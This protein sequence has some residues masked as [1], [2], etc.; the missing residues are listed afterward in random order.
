M[1]RFSTR[2]LLRVGVLALV[3]GIATVSTRGQAPAAK[4]G[5]WPTYGGDLAS[6]RYSPLDQINASNFSKLQLAFR[7]KTENLGPRPE[8]QFQSTP[9]MVNGRLFTTA[10]TRRA[11]V[12]L[13]ATT[14]EMLWMH[15]VD[16]GKRGEAA[17]RQLS[18]RGLSY[19]T[20]GKE[21][22]IIYVTPGYQMVALDA[23]TGLR[24]PNFGAGGIVDLKTGLDQ[25]GLD[26]TTAEIGLHAAPIISKDIIV[27]GAAHREGGFPKSKT[28]VKGYIRGFDVRT[29]KRVWVFHTI[30]MKG[31]AGYE[32]WD[33]DAA[34]YTGNAGVWAQMS[35]DEELGIVYMPVELPTGDY[36]GGHRHGGKGTDSALYGESLV[37]LDIKTGQKKWHYQLV[38]HGIWDHDIPC[39]PILMDLVVDGKPVKAVA[40]PTKQNWLYVFDRATGKPVWPIEERPVEKGDVPGEWYSPTQPFVTKPPAYERQGV[41]VNDLIDYTPELRAE[42]EKLV[43]Q[44]KIGPIFTPPVVSKWEGPRG[45]LMLPDVTGGANWQG[46]SFDPE[47]KRFYIFTN[48]TI[49][50]LGLLPPNE[51]QSDMLFGRGAA[52]NPNPAPA[53]AAGAPGGGGGGLNVRGLPLVK[54]PYAT[55]TAIDMNKGEQLWRIAHGDT[56]DAIKNNPALK[57]LTIPRTGR[58]GRIGVLTT[59]T[60]LIAGDGGFNTTPEGR[61]AYLRAYDKAT[62]ADAGQVFM[63]AP[64]TGSPMTYSINGTQYIAV[65]VSGPGFAGELLVYKLGN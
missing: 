5:E 56:A 22:R 42:A 45:T 64:Q 10:G 60:L 43:S 59:K 6:T 62:G 16:E 51:G 41:T 50:T 30:P 13:S 31:E 4:V 39:A 19:W 34:S 7:F 40:Q 3:V 29:G 47:T 17:P 11:A 21:E 65:A 37:A 26:L 53:P 61:G 44:Y 14:G 52:R 48:V 28:N 20:D 38:H 18:G 36:Y 57:G 32:T 23:K 58:Q 55:I 49:T 46:G 8:F 35:A 27:I 9:L 2:S 33:P 12:A 24:V 63:P 54:P 15:S 1:N 25:E